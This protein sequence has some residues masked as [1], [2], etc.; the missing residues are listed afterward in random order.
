[1]QAIALIDRDSRR[2]ISVG[3][4]AVEKSEELGVAAML[5]RPC[6][7]GILFDRQITE[8]VVKQVVGSIPKDERIRCV[9]GVPSGL[10]A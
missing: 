7:N 3:N 6:K 4:T 8:S 2:I 1:M 10:V 9:I 5:G